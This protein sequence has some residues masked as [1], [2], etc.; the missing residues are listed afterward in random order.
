LKDIVAV[1]SPDVGF[2]R[3]PSTPVEKI[4]ETIGAQGKIGP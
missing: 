2:G 3:L 4:L 1:L